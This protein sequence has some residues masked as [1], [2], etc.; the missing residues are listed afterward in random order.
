MKRIAMVIAAA[1]LSIG[2]SAC[3]GSSH[4]PMAPPPPPPPLSDK[5]GAGF[6]QDFQASSSAT[7]NPVK[8]GDTIPVDPSSAPT[9]LH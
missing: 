5:F 1:G 2:L 7:P 4:G 6:S 3:S 9:S 8:A